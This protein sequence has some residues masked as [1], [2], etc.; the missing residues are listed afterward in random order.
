MTVVENSLSLPLVIF[1]VFPTKSLWSPSW[2]YVNQPSLIVA[3]EGYDVLITILAVVTG[4][5]CYNT[6]EKF[7]KILKTATGNNSKEKRKW[8][9][10]GYY[11]L[12]LDTA[13]EYVRNNM[14]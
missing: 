13:Y 9:D 12:D 1:L 7:V 11:F 3:S 5:N 10:H 4:Q 2:M 8:K 6:G 14:I